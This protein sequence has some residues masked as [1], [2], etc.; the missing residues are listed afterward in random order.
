MVVNQINWT[1][2]SDKNEALN[3]RKH[4]CNLRNQAKNKDYIGMKIF[5]TYGI[6][7]LI[8]ND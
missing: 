8:H 3:L 6:T 2:Q 1:L 5:D 7:G 4:L